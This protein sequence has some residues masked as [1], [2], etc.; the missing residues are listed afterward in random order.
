[1]KGNTKLNTILLLIKLTQRVM[2]ANE[3]ILFSSAVKQPETI[4][5]VLGHLIL[6]WKEEYEHHLTR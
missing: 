4:Y 5:L 3:I 2:E 1:M 6:F